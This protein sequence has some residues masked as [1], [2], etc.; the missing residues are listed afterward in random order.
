M[1]V[2]LQVTAIATQ[3]QVQIMPQKHLI[4]ITVASRKVSSLVITPTATIL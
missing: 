3:L 4:H 1:E 2:Q